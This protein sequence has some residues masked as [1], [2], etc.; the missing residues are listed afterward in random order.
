MSTK[1]PHGIRNDLCYAAALFRA[2]AWRWSEA[3]WITVSRSGLSVTA[4]IGGFCQVSRQ[5][6][7]G[8]VAGSATGRLRV[9]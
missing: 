7:P 6:G 4:A 2:F 3:A 5:L 8:L 1:L 9:G